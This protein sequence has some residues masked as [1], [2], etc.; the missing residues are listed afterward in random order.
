MGLSGL[1]TGMMGAFYAHY[2]GVVSPRVLGLEV[3]IYLVIMV[4]LGG[5]G[6]FPGPAIGAFVIIFVS[7]WLREFQ[8]WR[9][10]IFGALVVILVMLAP[11]GLMGAIDSLQ[12][13]VRRRNKP[14]PP[15]PDAGETS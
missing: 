13:R 7:D 12:A 1:L 9:M 4:L 5:V 14:R 10:L 15:A 6:K 11:R 3:F 8:N 2:T